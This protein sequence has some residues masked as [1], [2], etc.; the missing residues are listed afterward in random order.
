MHQQIFLFQNV[1]A[2]TAQ[3]FIS[4]ELQLFSETVIIVCRVSY[5]VPGVYGV[6]SVYGVYGTYSV[7]GVF[8]VYGVWC[9]WCFWCVWCAVSFGV[10]FF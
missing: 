10:L 7:Y 4:N 2:W 9:V 1:S 3:A 8:G 5:L 6:Y